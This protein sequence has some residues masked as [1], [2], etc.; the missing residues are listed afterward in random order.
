MRALKI[1]IGL[2][3]TIQLFAQNGPLPGTEVGNHGDPF[4]NEWYRSKLKVL[5]ILSKMT[6]EYLTPST[7]VEVREWLS[8]VDEAGESTFQKLEKEPLQLRQRVLLA[9]LAEI[10]KK[11]ISHE[12]R[13][14]KKK[15]LK[16]KKK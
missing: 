16:V 4:H 6:K 7:P 9:F 1:L 12:N 13:T 10:L 8:K 11:R 2:F 15:K 14:K 5:K 3:I